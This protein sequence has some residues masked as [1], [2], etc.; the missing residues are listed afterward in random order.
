MNIFSPDEWSAYR[1]W[2]EPCVYADY[3]FL[4]RYFCCNINLLAP[5]VGTSYEGWIVDSEILFLP[6]PNF[7]K[8]SYLVLNA[9]SIS[10]LKVKTSGGQRSSF[11]FG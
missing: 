5:D 1:A 2:L 6:D 10:T 9:I 3:I 11:F 4:F 7:Q 8:V